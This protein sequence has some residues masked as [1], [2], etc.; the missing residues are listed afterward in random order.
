ME[1]E[2]CYYADYLTGIVLE[3]LLVDIWLSGK[4]ETSIRLGVKSVREPGL[5]GSILSLFYFSFF[6]QDLLSVTEG[7]YFQE[8]GFSLSE[9]SKSAFKDADL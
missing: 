5:K 8:G 9:S 7:K 6:S 2:D 3:T 1:S 4:A